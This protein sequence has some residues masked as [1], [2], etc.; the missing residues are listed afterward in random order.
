MSKTVLLGD[1]VRKFRRRVKYLKLV[2]NFV[3][4]LALLIFRTHF[5]MTA[6]RKID[7]SGDARNFDKPKWIKQNREYPANPPAELRAYRDSLY[8]IPQKYRLIPEPSLNIIEF[9]E[10]KLPGTTSTLIEYAANN[11]FSENEPTEDIGCLANRNLPSRIFVNN[12][13]SAFGQA[14]LDGA[15]SIDD[16]HYKGGFLPLWTV[17]YWDTAH[18]IVEDQKIWQQVLQWLK[19]RD[20]NSTRRRFFSECW[21]L[22]TILEWNTKIR[23]PGGAGPV[24]NFAQ[25]L[26]DKMVTG[27]IVDM[28][29][30]HLANRIRED[31]D[32]S[33]TYRVMTL[34]FQDHI[35]KA[36]D[37]RKS[38]GYKPP[39]FLREIIAEMKNSPRIWLFPVHMKLKHYLGFAIDFKKHIIY[40][41]KHSWAQYYAKKLTESKLCR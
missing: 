21:T 22:L 5:E 19:Q 33:K 16:P 31:E 40:H 9:T 3:F 18:E 25:L 17:A 23:L 2:F 10:L 15:K 38:E 27:N 30:E 39:N 6:T 29:I 35:N 34:R 20:D 26:G 1:F 4:P 28:M 37:A 8:E 7:L 12:V 11:S 36:W 32:D 24:S 13:K 41:G 14:I